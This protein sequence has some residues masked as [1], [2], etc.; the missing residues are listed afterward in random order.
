MYERERE[1]ETEREREVER[2]NKKKA[3][4]VANTSLSANFLITTQ[5]ANQIDQLI[6][7]NNS[8]VSNL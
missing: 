5:P 8:F 7:F 4:D 1:R 2:A 3:Y 6:L